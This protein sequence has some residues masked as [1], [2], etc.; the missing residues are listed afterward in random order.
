M[1]ESVVNAEPES[2]EE[3]GWI[4]GGQDYAARKGLSVEEVERW[5]GPR[6]NYV[7][8]QMPETAAV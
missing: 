1:A 7:P 8:E 2:P 4:D 5:L 3:E 6:L